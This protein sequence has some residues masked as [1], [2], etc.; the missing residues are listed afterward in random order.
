MKKNSIKTDKVKSLTDM[1]QSCFI[2][3]GADKD[4]WNFETYIKPYEEKI[5]KIWFE[6][7]YT[8][9]LNDLKNNYE[10]KHNVYQDSEGCIYNSIVKKS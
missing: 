10:I 3:G 2:Y 4:S 6:R 9:S 8:M 7:I 5:G 1:I